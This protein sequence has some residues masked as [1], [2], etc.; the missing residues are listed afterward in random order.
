M[1]PVVPLEE[2]ECFD[3][4]NSRSSKSVS[5]RNTTETLARSGTLR[6]GRLAAPEGACGWVVYCERDGELCPVVLDAD[7]RA[8]TARTLLE[9]LASRRPGMPVT[10]ENLA[11][12][13]PHRAGL[14]AG[15]L[16]NVLT[17]IEMQVLLAE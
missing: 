1:P 2:G 10:V 13:D 5:W 3:R 7:G 15:G 6:G 12:D 14:E 11:L 9:W 16:V 17:R 8:T 4:L